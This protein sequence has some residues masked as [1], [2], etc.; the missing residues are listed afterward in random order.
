MKAL[1]NGFSFELSGLQANASAT[2]FKSLALSL[3]IQNQRVVVFRLRFLFQLTV[4]LLDTLCWSSSPVF[5]FQLTGRSSSPVF[6]SS[7]RSSPVS[8]PVFIFQLAGHRSPPVSSPVHLLVT[9]CHR[10]PPVSSPVHLL[11]TPCHRSSPV[12]SPVFIFQ[13][14]GHR[15][16]PVSSPVHLLDTPCWS[17]SPVSSPERFV[18]AHL[19]LLVHLQ[20]NC[21]RFRATRHRVAHFYSLFKVFRL[22][23]CRFCDSIVC[24]VLS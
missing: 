12:S 11:V 8:S 17:S 7:H 2:T 6:F 9:P 16:S 19:P 14:A 20:L 4:Q 1:P 23:Y 10:S 3:S 24:C 15:S 5:I 13:L 22:N 18:M 21:S